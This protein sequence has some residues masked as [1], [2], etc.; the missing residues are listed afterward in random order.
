MSQLVSG[1]SFFISACRRMVSGFPWVF[2]IHP[3]QIFCLVSV[4]SAGSLIVSGPTAFVSVPNLVSF[5][6]LYIS[7]PFTEHYDDDGHKIVTN[8]PLG[9]AP[10]EKEPEFKLSEEDPRL[11]KADIGYHPVKEWEEPLPTL[12]TDE[13]PVST[14][15]PEKVKMCQKVHDLQV[16]ILGTMG[17][18]ACREYEH[19]KVE[20][21]I[22]AVQ[23]D[24]SSCPLCKQALKDRAAVRTHLR[25]KHMESTPFTCDQCSKS[26][27][28]NQLLRSHM[29]T[30]TDPN[31]FQCP[32]AGCGKG[33]P[34]QGR[35][36]QHL[37]VHDES[38]HVARKY[39]G[40]VFNSKKNVGPHEV[41]C[42]KNP[43]PPVKDKK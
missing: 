40:K 38:K 27:G 37:K 14:I 32:Q 8:L 39:C 2:D 43:T 19:S 12:S 36:N 26:F 10:L 18:D 6:C 11:Y 34:S 28:D 33:Y 35:L 7:V 13:P 9:H 24:D 3:L 41:T 21:I 42:K 15:D 30:H 17:V 1:S 20:Y 31:K 25:A 16:E 22:E 5:S 23:V 4:V 29:K